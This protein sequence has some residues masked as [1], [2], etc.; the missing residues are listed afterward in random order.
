[1]MKVRKWVLVTDGG[2]GGGRDCVAA[3][4]ALH[5]GGYQ[6]GVTVSRG[7]SPGIPS[8]YSK[9][10]IAVPNVAEDGYVDAVKRE[11]E[12]G[13]YLTVICAS[14]AS[15]RALGQSGL[16]LTHKTVLSE[17]AR[18]AQIDVPA[19]RTYSTWDEAR[20]D[21]QNFT[22]PVVVKPAVRTFK[23]T[24]VDNPSQLTALDVAGG[25]VVVQ[26]WVEGQL[27]AVS[28]VIWRGTLVASTTERWLRIWPPSCGLAAAAITTKSDPALEDKLVRL[29]G[30]YEGIF[31]AQF[32]G[33]QL[34]DLNLRVHSSHSLSVAAGANL[35][36]IYCD[37]LN[38]M[39]VP[40][41]HARPGLFY[42]WLEGDIRH[43]VEALRAGTLSPIA[44]ARALAPH[45]GASHSIES[46]RDPGPMLAR[47]VYALRRLG[48]SPEERRLEH[49]HQ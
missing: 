17:E 45:R 42:R 13:P 3:V 31:C 12:S 46:L 39:S 37:L 22:Y 36:S 15:M 44:A 49:S 9:R 6:T 11:L 27:Q 18:K 32:A 26:E 35:V 34:I 47:L 23:A 29:L 24:R 4:R 38:G 8:R 2:N 40:R 20:A 25:D 1:M 41:T 10:R 30:D 5:A 33:S 19:S 28:G 16:Q 7:T 48:K 21:S 43:V 14:E